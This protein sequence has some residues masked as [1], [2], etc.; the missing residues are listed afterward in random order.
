MA[1]KQAGRQVGRP[2]VLQHHPEAH[3]SAHLDD[4]GAV[5]VE[6]PQFPIMALVRPPEGVDAGLQALAVGVVCRDKRKTG[7][8]RKTP[9]K[10]FTPA[11]KKRKAMA[12]V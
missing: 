2:A 3:S 11:P 8:K 1:D 12:G 9:S 10:R 7:N 5:V 4:V 6:V